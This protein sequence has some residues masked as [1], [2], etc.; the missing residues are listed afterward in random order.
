MMVHGA[1]RAAEM[2]E[3]AATVRALGLPDRLTRATADWQE[4]IAALRLPAGDADLV[5]RADRIL[6]SL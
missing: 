4:Q 6:A 2:R 5:D 3:A 1:R